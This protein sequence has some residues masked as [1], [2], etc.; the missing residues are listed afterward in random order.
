MITYIHDDR[1]TIIIMS[2]LVISRRWYIYHLVLSRRWC[3]YIYIYIYIQH[4]ALVAVVYLPPCALVTVV[5]IPLRALVT[6]VYI[7]PCALVTVVYIPP[8]AL[9]TVVYIPPCALVPSVRSALTSGAGAQAQP[10]QGASEGN[11][12]VVRATRVFGCWRPRTTP[13]KTPL[14]I[15]AAPALDCYLAFATV[16]PDL[17]MRR[18]RPWINRGLVC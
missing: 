4:C 1:H 10:P 12:R 15:L 8:C 7:P 5:Y 6:V 3:I 13:T 18:L 11:A 9:V 16:C 14:C 2:H 17:A